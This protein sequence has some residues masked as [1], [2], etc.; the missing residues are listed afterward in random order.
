MKQAQFEILGLAIVVIIIS[1]GVLFLLTFTLNTETHDPAS[2]FFNE[3]FAQNTLDAFLKTTHPTIGCEQYDNKEYYQLR[4]ITQQGPTNCREETTQDEL[5]ETLNEIINEY[6]R[7]EY[8][9]EVRENICPTATGDTNCNKLVEHGTCE[10]ERTNLGR[11]GRQTIP[12]Y[13]LPGSLE[14]VL[15]LCNP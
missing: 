5:E 2:Q 6:Q 15:W 8:K 1:V 14:I 12:K 10:P 9:F 7:V 11:P 13:P 3:Q 4:Y